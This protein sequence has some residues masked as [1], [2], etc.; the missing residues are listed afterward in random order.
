MRRVKRQAFRP[1]SLTAAILTPSIYL[2]IFKVFCL[3]V[4]IVLR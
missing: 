1:Y 2:Y 3:T 4:L